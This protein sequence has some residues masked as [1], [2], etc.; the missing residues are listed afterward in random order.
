[1]RTGSACRY[2]RSAAAGFES[3]VGGFFMT[4]FLVRTFVKNYGQTD[5]ASVRTAYGVMAS[6]VGI[7]CNLLLFAAKLA[8]G[9]LSGSISIMADAFNNLSDA[10]GSIVGFVGM[11][12]AEKPADADHPFGHGRVEYIA[13]FIVSIFVIQVGLELFKSSIGKIRRPEELVF[14]WTAVAILALSILVKCWLAVFNRRL[15]RRIRSSVMAATA[16]DAMGDVAATSAAVVSILV[17]GLLHVNIDGYI[18]LLVS[19]AVLLAGFG[20]ARDTLAPLIGEP[21]DADVYR[22]ITDFVESYD[23]IIGTHDLI[24]HNYGPSH[25]MA[26]IHAEV[27]GD[28]DVRE[29]H[30]IIDRIERDCAHSLGIFLVIHMDPVEMWDERSAE[31]RRVLAD[32]LARLDSRLSFH[33]FRVIDG[34]E[35]INLIFDLVVPR[36]YNSAMRDTIRSKVSEEVRLA[37]PR[38]CCVMTVENTYCAESPEP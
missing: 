5:D 6:V 32:V 31:Y 33:D 2:R 17:F 20:I 12:M 26:T 3:M 21:I 1:M 19:L 15:G 7:C 29:S 35:R 16:A 30:E 8:V 18:G 14:S 36:E 23:G 9:L 13:A 34:T 22:K 25:S 38:C 24:V 4:D 27:P 37:D 10:A 11:R 28:T